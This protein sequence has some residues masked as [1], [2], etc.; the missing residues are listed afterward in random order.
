M[1]ARNLPYEVS[2]N[3]IPRVIKFLQVRIKNIEDNM[4]NIT[5]ENLN[6]PY[7]R[8]KG[9]I[10]FTHSQYNRIKDEYFSSE[11]YK[12]TKINFEI[13]RLQKRYDSWKIQ[14]EIK[15]LEVSQ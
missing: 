7:F 12:I 8:I 3:V 9:G 11:N 5:N 2:R 15:Q 1:G 6:I 10:P 13:E 14:T 4:E